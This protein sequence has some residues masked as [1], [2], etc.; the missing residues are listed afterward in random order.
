VSVASTSRIRDL[1]RRWANR[2]RSATTAARLT[3]DN[4]ATAM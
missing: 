2:S 1:A 3:A 4:E